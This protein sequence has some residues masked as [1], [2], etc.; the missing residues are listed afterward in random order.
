MMISTALI[1]CAGLLIGG[2]IVAIFWNN[3]ISYLK[4]AIP[5]IS[6]VIHDSVAGVKVFL[7]KA[8]GGI[9]QIT[10]AYSQNM[11]TKKWKETIVRRTID[12]EQVPKEKRERLCMNEEF[13]ITQ[14]LQNKLKSA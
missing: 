9:M 11:E 5:K 8:T 10:K 7:L 3:I 14:E 6:E 1:L 12:E 13:D 4:R 2:G